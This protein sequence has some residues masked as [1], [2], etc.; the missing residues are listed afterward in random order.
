MGGGFKTQIEVNIK[1]KNS[2]KKIVHDAKQR[3]LQ[4]KLENQIEQLN[5]FDLGLSSDTNTVQTSNI[6]Y[7]EQ[8]S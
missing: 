6:D 2:N 4:K 7:I 8:M 1:Y 3:L 5:N